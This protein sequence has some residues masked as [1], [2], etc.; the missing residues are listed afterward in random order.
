MKKALLVGA[1]LL[2]SACGNKKKD[3]CSVTSVGTCAAA[4][5]SCGAT[6][7]CKDK[8]YELKCTPP[9]TQDVKQVDCQCIDGGVIGKTVQMT[10]P[11][12]ATAEA[13]QTACGWK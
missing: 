2:A 6:L 7:V 13:V 10:Y 3:E 12:N 11:L 8:P 5:A 9:A 4:G 1:L